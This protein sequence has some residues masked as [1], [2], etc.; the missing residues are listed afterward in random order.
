MKRFYFA[1]ALAAMTSVVF[2]SCDKQDEVTPPLPE[3]AELGFASVATANLVTR[4]DATDLNAPFKINLDA[5]AVYTTAVEGQEVTYAAGSGYTVDPS[6]TLVKTARNL[7]AWAPVG[8]SPVTAPNTFT[9]TPGSADDFVYQKSTSVSSANCTNLALTLNHAYAKLTFTLT[10]TNYNLPKS[11]SSLVV[12][13]TPG[14]STID[15]STGTYATTPTDADLTVVSTATTFDKAI[16]TLVVPKSETVAM[17]LDCTL[18]G[19]SY[20]GIA[21]S[22]INKLEPGANYNVKITITGQ[23]IA[24]TGVQVPG[25]TNG[26][27]GSADLK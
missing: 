15:I 8:V 1:A 7:T 11:L 17:T 6:I 14:A 21:V 12:K 9:L 25:W 19:V 4:A 3:K 26:E 23:S 18:D 16:A 2:S 5:N 22:G 24:I 20:T 27:E 13:G 10:A